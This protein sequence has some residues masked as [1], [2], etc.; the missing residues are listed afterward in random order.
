MHIAT[1][2]DPRTLV[3][4][5]KNVMHTYRFLVIWR[6]LPFPNPDAKFYLYGSDKSEALALQEAITDH[7][8]G[9]LVQRIEYL[10]KEEVARLAALKNDPIGEAFKDMG[11]ITK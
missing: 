10:P 4:M 5:V 11:L 3:P 9:E 1:A 7:P 2:Q 8:V 6:D